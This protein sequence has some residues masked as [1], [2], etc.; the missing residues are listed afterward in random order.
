MA[1][2]EYVILSQAVEGQQEEFERWYDEIHLA[3]V[4]KIPGVVAARRSRIVN[5][6]AT[7]LDIPAW[8]SLATYEMETDDP[9][10]VLAAIKA[11]SG[12]AA[13]P[14]SDALNRTGLVQ[15]V[16]GPVNKPN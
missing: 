1:R 6:E 3:D 5:L 10:K 7:R 2:Y 4:L 9:K 11:V 16:A 15:I 14:L 13:M 8:T 12:T